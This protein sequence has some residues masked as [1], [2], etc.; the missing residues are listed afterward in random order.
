MVYQQLRQLWIDGSLLSAGGIGA[1]H[2]IQV[3][4]PDDR[5]QKDTTNNSHRQR[6]RSRV[7]QRVRRTRLASGS[8]VEVEGPAARL[9]MADIRPGFAAHRSGIPARVEANPAAIPNPD[10]RVAGPESAESTAVSGVAAVDPRILE[11]S[12]RVAAGTVRLVVPVQQRSDFAALPL[13]TWYECPVYGPSVQRLK[14]IAAGRTA[15]GTMTKDLSAIAVFERFTRPADWTG[16]WPGISISAINHEYLREWISAALAGGLSKGYLEP[17][18]GHLAWM[19]SVAVDRE[20]LPRVPKKPPV[21]QIAASKAGQLFDD[22]DLAVIFETDGQILETLDRIHDELAA[23]F[24]LQTAFVLAVSVGLRPSDLFSLCWSDLRSIDGTPAICS[25]PEKTK[26]HGTKVRIPIA[27]CVC[28]RLEELRRR[29]DV[30]CCNAGQCKGETAA[31]SAQTAPQTDTAGLIF[32]RLTSAIAKDPEHS[33]AARRRNAAMRSAAERAGFVFPSRR[34]KPWQV[35]RATAN[36]RLERHCAGIGEFVLGHATG[37]VNKK[38]YRQRWSEA[39]AAVNS[40]PQ[41]SRFLVPI[42]SEMD[43]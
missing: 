22:D 23:D 18:T 3:F 31:E 9:T 27:P 20:V 12:A 42:S 8:Q 28:A 14:D 16:E 13:R 39:V 43:G 6:V 15:A 29:A 35:A 5:Q 24:E 38:H 30:A 11:I 41:P 21:R 40:L 34:S 37:S 36:E 4:N 32:P 33:H 2:V 17:L 7:M 25:T 1:N 26:R 19:L 10:Q